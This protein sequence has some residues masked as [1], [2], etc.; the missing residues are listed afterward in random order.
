MQLVGGRG[1]TNQSVILWKIVLTELEPW[2][3]SPTGEPEDD[4]IATLLFYARSSS[5]S[6]VCV[7][8]MYYNSLTNIPG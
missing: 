3:S 2:L 8:D 6:T 7:P 5:C 4:L 1:K